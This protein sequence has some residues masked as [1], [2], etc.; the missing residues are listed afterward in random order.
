MIR[1]NGKNDVSYFLKLIE[2]LQSIKIL[3]LQYFYNVCPLQLAG[4]RVPPDPVIPFSQDL[5][6]MNFEVMYCDFFSY[7]HQKTKLSAKKNN[8]PKNS[9]NV[10]SLTCIWTLFRFWSAEARGN[11]L[12]FFDTVLF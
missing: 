12:A 1:L 3:K 8:I 11:F 5:K 9:T 2:Q 6:K 10:I 7:L 4:P